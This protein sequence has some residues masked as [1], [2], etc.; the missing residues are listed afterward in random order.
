MAGTILFH[1]NAGYKK[2]NIIRTN[3]D[4]EF[5][6]EASQYIDD[7]PPILKEDNIEGIADFV[8]QHYLETGQRID[9]TMLPETAEGSWKAP[10]K[11]TAIS[12]SKPTE[13]EAEEV[14][15]D[16]TKSLQATEAT[17]KKRTRAAGVEKEK[18]VKAKSTKKR[19]RRIICNEDDEEVDPNPIIAAKGK[20]LKHLKAANP[21][22]FDKIPSGQAKKVQKLSEELEKPHE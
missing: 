4:I 12:K 20:G 14:A 13:A 18:A 2:I 3:D 15:A 6:R 10:R 5:R 7:F 11:K 8:K 9:V 19:P 22:V 16:I 17:A 1:M 21:E